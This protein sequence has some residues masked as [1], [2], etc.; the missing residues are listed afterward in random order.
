[1]IGSS[2]YYKLADP[3]LRRE[4]NFEACFEKEGCESSCI[5]L[6][7]LAVARLVFNWIRR[8]DRFPVPVRRKEEEGRTSAAE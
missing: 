8:P 7:A 4:S 6:T 5:R 3:Q 1:M 2:F